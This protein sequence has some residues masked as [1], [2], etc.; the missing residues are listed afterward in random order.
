[1]LAT[2]PTGYVT[3]ARLRLA[4]AEQSAGNLAEAVAAFDEVAKDG[5][6][7]PILADYARLQAAML[8]L[9]SASFTEV[10]NR[11]TPLTNDLNPWRYSAREYLGMALYKAGRPGEARNYF[12]RLVADRTTPPGIADRARM[13]VALLSEADEAKAAP[14]VKTD[15]P[16]QP[17]KDNKG[18]PKAPDKKIN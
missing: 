18:K 13:M 2:A 7:D 14:G 10:K 8:K 4:A 6:V 9:D 17:A 12:Q 3:L 5:S 1:L 16:P 15:A 11:L